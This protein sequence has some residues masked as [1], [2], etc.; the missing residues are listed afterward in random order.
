MQECLNKKFMLTRNYL[1][2]LMLYFSSHSL[3]G[4]KPA[5]GMVELSQIDTE[6]YAHPLLASILKLSHVSRMM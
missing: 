6:S 1:K 3:I 4:Y 5:P 2:I